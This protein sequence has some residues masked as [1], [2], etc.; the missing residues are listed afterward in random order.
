MKI[1]YLFPQKIGL[2]SLVKIKDVT[3]ET[4]VFVCVTASPNVPADCCWREDFTISG[5]FFI[6]STRLRKSC[7][8]SKQPR[9][10]QCVVGGSGFIFVRFTSPVIYLL[11]LYKQY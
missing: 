1:Y 10:Q 2:C 7:Q 9:W 8:Q 5:S 4:Q 6:C 11:Q 3:T